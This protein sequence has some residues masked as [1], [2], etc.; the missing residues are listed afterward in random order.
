EVALDRAPAVLAEGAEP[1]GVARAG[2]TRQEV[3]RSLV[4]VPAGLLDGEGEG[5]LAAARAADEARWPGFAR[6]IRRCER[7]GPRAPGPGLPRARTRSRSSLRRP[8]PDPRT[9]G[10]E[11][12]GTEPCTRREARGRTPRRARPRR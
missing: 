11:R 6:G 10:R 2:H 5:A 9:L 4:G 8:Q 1:G 3:A 7:G 12:R